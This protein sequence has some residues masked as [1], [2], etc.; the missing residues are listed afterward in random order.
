MPVRTTSFFIPS[1]AASVPFLLEDIYFKGGMRSVGNAAARDAIVEYARKP[2]MLVVTADTNEIWQ[3]Q[4]DSITYKLFKGSVDASGIAPI[5]VLING[6]IQIDSNYILPQ[7][8][9]IGDFLILDTDSVPI[10]QHAAVTGIQRTRVSVSY[11]A[12]E[13]ID[14]LGKHDFVV[15][16]STAV[17]VLE[18][19]LDTSYIQLQGF[20]KP[21]R[22]EANP[23]TFVSTDS[24]LEDSGITVL[25]DGSQKKGRRYNTLVNLESPT[26]TNIY[27]T[28][29]NV[30]SVAVK[31]TVTFTFLIQQ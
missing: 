9:N 3:L 8:G 23:Y 11:T 4:A 1:N 2:G 20:S 6:D 12:T 25:P 5:S 16:M 31:P 19:I 18:T 24:I 21:D 7:K 26:T 28:F 15:T 17:T 27:W 30:G 22:L 13:P 29:T 14:A 10:W